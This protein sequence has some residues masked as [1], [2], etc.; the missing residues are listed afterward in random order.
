M[1]TR[2]DRHEWDK[3]L[4]G[5]WFEA[6]AG[7]LIQSVAKDVGLDW[8]VGR[9][10]IVDA[11]GWCSREIDLI[12][13]DKEQIEGD[14]VGCLAFPEDAV[15][16]VFHA[17]RPKPVRLVVETK[18]G[19]RAPWDATNDLAKL[20]LNEILARCS[21]AKAVYVCRVE[22]RDWQARVLRI[23]KKLRSQG[24]PLDRVAVVGLPHVPDDRSEAEYGEAT[25]AGIA[26][27]R[28]LI[29]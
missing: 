19:A 8:H 14:P 3:K 15:R 6:W 24:F 22:G 29:T 9:G 13:A 25:D 7:G 17:L 20:D 27:L 21:R 4:L 23:E 12:A 5:D 16:S 28:G 2:F 1:K 10:H 11:N 26:K 18:E